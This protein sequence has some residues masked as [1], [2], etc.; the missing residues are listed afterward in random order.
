MSRPKAFKRIQIP[1]TKEQWN[2]LE[3][4]EKT[5]KLAKSKIIE[6]MLGEIDFSYF[7]AGV[8]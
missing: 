3:E 6:I 4:K 1:I 5:Y 2:I 8:D 7:G